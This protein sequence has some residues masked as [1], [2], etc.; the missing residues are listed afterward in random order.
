MIQAIK[1]KHIRIDSLVSVIGAGAKPSGQE[2]DNQLQESQLKISLGNNNE[3]I[4][5]QN[6][7]N[8]FNDKTIIR[9]FI[10]EKVKKAS[11]VFYN[12]TGVRM[13]EVM[14]NQK[15]EGQV[16]VEAGNIS[17]GIYSYSLLIEGKTT[18]TKRMVKNR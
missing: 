1:E 4:L 12:S 8:P 7:P 16:E 15:G 5:Y 14:L 9:Y 2:N 10:P 18:D 11:L 6:E 17:Q 13:K 3:A